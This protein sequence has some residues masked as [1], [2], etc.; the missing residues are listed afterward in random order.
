MMMFII[1]TFIFIIIFERDKERPQILSQTGISLSFVM[2]TLCNLGSLPFF[3]YGKIYITK[4]TTLTIF[5]HA[6]Q[7][8]KYI[9]V[10]QFNALSNLTLLC[11][12]HHHPAPEL[13]HHPK[14]KV[15]TC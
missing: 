13:C 1:I 9:D 5:K 10:I 11:N 3:S 4:F 12:H 7:C 14:L 8:I 15:C 2:V 6:I